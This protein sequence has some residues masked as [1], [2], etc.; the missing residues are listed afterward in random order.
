MGASQSSASDVDEGEGGANPSL[1][2]DDDV[3]QLRSTFRAICH[4]CVPHSVP[5]SGVQRLSCDA[6]EQDRFAWTRLQVPTYL[7]ET[8]VM[9]VHPSIVLFF[10]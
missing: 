1:F 3:T 8:T 7:V 4:S 9:V 2:S 6:A 10:I 5:P